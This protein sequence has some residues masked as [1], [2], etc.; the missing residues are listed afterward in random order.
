MQLEFHPISDYACVDTT[1]RFCLS[2]A[3]VR[4]E[5]V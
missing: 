5:W 1:E 2:R 4:G 3:L